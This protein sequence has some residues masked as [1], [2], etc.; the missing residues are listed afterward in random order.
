LSFFE[1]IDTSLLKHV[2]AGNIKHDKPP[3]ILQILGLGSCVAITFY[4]QKT[5][6]GIM[7]H[8]VLPARDRDDILT[9]EFKGKYANTAVEELINW[10]KKNK[11]DLSEIKVKLVGGAKMFKNSVSDVLNISERNIESIKEEFF[12][13]NIKID[14][15]ELGGT[16]GRSILFNLENGEIRIF[17]AGGKLKAII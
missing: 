12:K 1:N 16:K 13:Y 7:A 15:T 10:T 3:Y 11:F 9:P 6:S 2:L 4:H 5:K 17:H 14:K 8:V